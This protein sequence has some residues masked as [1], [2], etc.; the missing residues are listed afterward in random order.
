MQ[1]HLIET[2]ATAHKVGYRVALARSEEEVREAQRLR[3][4][5]FVEE[6]GARILSRLPHHDIDHYDAFC[7]HLIVRESQT[8]RIV[9]TYR[10][11]SPAAARRIGNY[12]SE[13]EFHI[14][15]LQN[16]RSRMVEVGRSCIH[17][18]HRSGAVITLLWAGLADYMVSNNHE[19]LIGCASIGM[20]DGGHNAANLFSQIAPD[21]MAPAEY[22]VFP[23]HGLPF[24][25]LAT[26]QPALVPPLIKGYLRVGA[27][28]CGEPAWDPD[29]NTADLL[30]LLPMS[31]M[32]PRYMRHFVKP[33]DARAA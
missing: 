12:Y 16:L 22:R 4:K 3:Y 26:G 21:Y 19:Y 6:L 23:Q 9:G 10:I 27:W 32:N 7:E 30:L 18:E 2:A 24:E 29:F 13:N 25:R 8:D 14:N 11:L 15:R 17:P 31:R 1:E 33:A 28:I 5:V 20:A